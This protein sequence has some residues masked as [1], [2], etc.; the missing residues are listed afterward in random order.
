MVDLSKGSSEQVKIVRP[1][2]FF[3]NVDSIPVTSMDTRRGALRT[4]IIAG[5]PVLSSAAIAK[6]AK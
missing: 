6:Q 5:K 3:T 2:A 1:V 4:Y